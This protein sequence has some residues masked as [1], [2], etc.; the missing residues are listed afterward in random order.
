MPIHDWT[1]V[2]AGIFHHFH[3]A[4]IEEIQRALNG[5]LL[6]P[7][8]YA[9]SEQIA[10]G[11]V[12]DVLTLQRPV[13]P[14]V[15]VDDSAGGVALATAPPKV[16]FHSRA[17]GDVYATRA[18][19]VVIRHRSGHQVIAMVEIVSRG[20][21]DTRTRLTAFVDKAVVALR[22]GIH[23]LIIDLL[24]PGPHDPQGIHKVIW[25]ELA[26]EEFALPSDQR[27]TL[28][29][30]MGGECPESFVQPVGLGDGLPEMPV[31]LSPE[32][33]VPLPLEPTYQSAWEAVPTYWRDVVASSGGP[34]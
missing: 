32:R 13:E 15:P 8:Y 17:E 27:L 25:D 26:D 34:T 30:Y 11:V 9:L 3:H 7:G 28:A 21:K 19:A 20:N 10:G 4:W 14:P 18:K 31:F 24:P 5:G 12:P 1:R 29:A 16:R 23:L 33:Y 22:D 6:P 2:D